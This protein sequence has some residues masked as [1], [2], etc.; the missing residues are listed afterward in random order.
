MCGWRGGASVQ[1]AGGAQSRWQEGLSPG[2]RRGSVQVAGGLSPGG[3]YYCFLEALVT[4]S[5]QGV[6]K[7]AEDALDSILSAGPE[8]GHS[9]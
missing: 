7:L 5:Q 6:K 4:A 3:G 8:P 1:V 2:G 9:T